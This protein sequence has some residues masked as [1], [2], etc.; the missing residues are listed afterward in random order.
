[1]PL[2]VACYLHPSV[3]E[4]NHWHITFPFAFLAHYHGGFVHLIIESSDG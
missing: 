2:D 1:M 3:P 4:T